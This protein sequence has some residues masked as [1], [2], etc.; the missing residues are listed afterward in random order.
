MLLFYY[1]VKINL[2]D[3]FLVISTWQIMILMLECCQRWK[4]N[5]ATR[6]N[7][8]SLTDRRR[9]DRRPAYQKRN[10]LT[11]RIHGTA[12]RV[13]LQKECSGSTPDRSTTFFKKSLNQI[14]WN[15][16]TCIS[17]KEGLQGE[18]WIHSILKHLFAASGGLTP[19]S[20]HP[21][22]RPGRRKTWW[23]SEARYLVPQPRGT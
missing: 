17:H 14:G 15:S 10:T 7:N 2:N 1:K 20:P 16:R 4:R 13:A 19:I 18:D 3:A 22:G 12:Q 23:Y 6:A 21:K 8:S 5:E 11:I 9:Q